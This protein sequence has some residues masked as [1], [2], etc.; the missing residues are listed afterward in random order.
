MKKTIIVFS[1]LQVSFII[2]FLVRFLSLNLTLKYEVEEETIDPLNFSYSLLD[3]LGMY[4]IIGIIF[5][6]SFLVIF[7]FFKRTKNRETN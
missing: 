6:I 4:V 3:E 5:N 1:I 2:F 7:S